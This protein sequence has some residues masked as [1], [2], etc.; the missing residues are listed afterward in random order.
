MKIL[1]VAIL[2][3]AAVAVYLK[4]SAVKSK[5]AAIREKLSSENEIK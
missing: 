2:I 5:L 3:G 1:I 4:R